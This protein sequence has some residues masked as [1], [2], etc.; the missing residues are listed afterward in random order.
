MSCGSD[1]HPPSMR[2][3]VDKKQQA[4]L[5]DVRE[6]ALGATAFVPGEK[7]TW[8][9]WEDSAVAPEQ[10]GNYL[11]D[12]RK[13]Y[14]KYGYNPSL[15]GHF[16]QGCVH[17][18]VDFDLDSEAGVKKYRSFMEEAADLIVRYGGSFS[19]EHGDG[20]SRAE[21]LAKCSAPR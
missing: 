15:Y 12:L 7:D 2:L 1:P 16:G 6:A 19:G 14:D 18:R 17:C 13:L 3:L 5:W 11:R 21:L 4:N 9:G 10:V 20:Q 8:P